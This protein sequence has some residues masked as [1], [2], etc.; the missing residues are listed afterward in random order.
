MAVN[1]EVTSCLVQSA[2]AIVK[3]VSEP[4][5]TQKAITGPKSQ[6]TSFGTTLWHR[7]QRYCFMGISFAHAQVEVLT[8]F[9]GKNVVV[10]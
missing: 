4:W 9:V 2:C 5:L 7:V 8:I 1:L 10:G 3:W 6:G